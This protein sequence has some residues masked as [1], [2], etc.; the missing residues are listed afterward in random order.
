[1]SRPVAAIAEPV[2]LHAQGL[3]VAHGRGVLRMATQQAGGGKAKP[4]AGSGQCM[5]MVGMVAAKAD[6]AGRV[7]PP[8][9]DQ[10]VAQ[11]EPLVAADQR[12]DQVQT[13]HCELDLSALSPGQAQRL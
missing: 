6:Q 4:F 11:L 10:M 8:G 5:Q 13:Q 1:M 2:Q 3:Q 9:F 7:A 12:V